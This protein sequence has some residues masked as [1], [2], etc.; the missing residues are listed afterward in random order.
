[1]TRLVP[2]VAVLVCCIAPAGAA[3]PPVPTTPAAPP[4]IARFLRI[5]TPGAPNMLPDGSLLV[6]D[7]PDGVSQLYRVTPGRGSDGTPS[8]APGNATVTPLTHYEDGLSNYTVSPDGHTVILMHAAGGDENTQLTLMDLNTPAAPLL[9]VLANPAVQA[10]VNAWFKDGSGFLYSANQDAPNDF[11]LYRYDIATRK[12]TRVLAQSG[13]W[14]VRAVTKD[15]TRALVEHPISASD[16]RCFELNLATSAL[17]DV[18]LVPPGGTA[19]CQVVDYMPDERS[20]LLRSDYRDGVMRLYVRELATNA[21]RQPIASLGRYDLEVAG[22]NDRRTFL[23]AAT[24]EDGFRVMHVFTVPDFKPL[25]VPASDRGLVSPAGFHDSTLTWTRTDAHTPSAAFAT[26]YPNRV[27]RGGARAAAALVTRQLTWPD[28][29]GIDLDKFPL[30]ALVRY[31]AFDHR[32]IPAFLYLPAGYTPGRHIPFIVMYHGGPESQSRPQFSAV[33]QY[34]VARGYG[35]LLP[36]V[37]GSTGYG[38]AFQ[39]L[40]DYRLR[41]NSVRDGVDGAEWLVQSGYA[42]PGRIATYGGSYGGFMSVAC[43]VE[44]QERVDKGARR[45]RLFGAAVDVVGIVNLRTFLAGTSGYRRKLREVEYGPLADT[46]FLASVS[47]IERVDKIQVPMFIGHGFNDPRVPVGEAMQLAMA[48]KQR[49]RSPRL[50]IA[51]DEGHGFA[52]LDNRIYFYERMATFLDETIGNQR[53]AIA[54]APAQEAA[55]N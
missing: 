36:N 51:P 33:T 54:P 11:F 53:Q 20:V 21:V 1:M 17:H 22:L 26:L 43:I 2:T 47:S 55:P 40:D 15:G 24:N 45:E 3:T 12:H 46:T 23:F 48:L 50:F 25:P 39:M 4:S 16:I 6:R 5:R 10:A 28:D 37:R 29:Q 9:P 42:S 27:A 34:F 31:P 19:A 18:T 35:V 30:P 13:S 14:E 49:G 38:R 41:W 44:D 7:S 8:Y 32:T 52:K